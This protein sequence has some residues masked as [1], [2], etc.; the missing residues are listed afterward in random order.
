MSIA[1]NESRDGGLIV[2]VIALTLGSAIAYV[3]CRPT[4][5]DTGITVGA[6]VLVAGA[7]GAWRPRSWWLTGLLAGIP[8]PVFNY[9]RHRSLG[10]MVALVFAVIAAGIGAAV[11]RTRYAIR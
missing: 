1:T 2:G 3:D 10:A 8:I 9:V 6:L 7:F 5:D 4:W 11:G